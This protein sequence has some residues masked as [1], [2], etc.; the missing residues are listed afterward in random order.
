MNES[1]QIMSGEELYG[2]PAR[3]GGYAFYKTF[4]V[5]TYMTK[6]PFTQWAR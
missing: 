3:L 4:G 6:C 1:T 5:H 2:I